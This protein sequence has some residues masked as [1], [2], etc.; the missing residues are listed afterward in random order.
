MIFGLSFW[1]NIACR[2]D[3]QNLVSKIGKKNPKKRRKL[4]LG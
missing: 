4:L 2:Y 3:P 1:G